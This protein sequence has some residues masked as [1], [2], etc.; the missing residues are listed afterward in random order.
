M[1]HY[2]AWT[3]NLCLCESATDV[4]VNDLLDEQ[5][6][7]QGKVTRWGWITNLPLRARTVESVMRAGRGRWEISEREV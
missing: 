4:T 3:S 2:F 6:N 5:T 7:Q 1:Q